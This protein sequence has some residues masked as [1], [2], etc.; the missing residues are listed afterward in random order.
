MITLTVAAV[1]IG[2]AMA[3][4]AVLGPIRWP[5]RFTP[6]AAMMAVLATTVAIDRATRPGALRPFSTLQRRVFAV[7]GAA[8]VLLAVALRPDVWVLIGTAFVL[9]VATPGV[10]ALARRGR[11]QVLGAVMVLGSVVA[12]V[13]VG[14][15]NPQLTEL[16]DWGGASRRSEVSA[17]V[18][19]FGTGRALVLLHG[20]AGVPNEGGDFI[21]RVPSGEYPLISP[22]IGEYVGTGHAATPVAAQELAMCAGAYGWVCPDAPRLVLTPEP[23]TGLA[24]V[25][26]MDID[27]IIIQRGQILEAFEGIDPPGWVATQEAEQWVLFERAAP[28]PAPSDTVSWA[29][30][31]VTVEPA[32]DGGDLVSAPDGGRL[33]L[34]RPWVPGLQVKIDGRT[35]DAD[36]VRGVY[37]IVEL[38]AGTSGELTVYYRLPRL[39]LLILAVLAGL[40]VGALSIVSAVRLGRGRRAT[41]TD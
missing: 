39:R 6:F 38:P 19:A 34:S 32:P 36:S 3:G 40:V 16:P 41:P 26:L 24:P 30:P 23:E 35:I 10:V 9:G 25:D 27:R 37:P 13:G 11:V 17:D 8:L 15:G 28:S 33:T 29:G 22:D 1:L 18:E 2:I 12:V 31:G 14:I 21:R 4:P 7:V 5:F 20:W